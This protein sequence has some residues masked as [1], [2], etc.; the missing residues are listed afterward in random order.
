MCGGF[1]GALGRTDGVRYN[2]MYSH[3]YNYLC[4]TWLFFIFFPR[5]S[6][7]CCFGNMVSSVERQF[8]HIEWEIAGVL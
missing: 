2:C 6:L 1:I 4:V 3:M 5:V 7:I 8:L